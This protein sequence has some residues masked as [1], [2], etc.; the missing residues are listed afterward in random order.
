MAAGAWSQEKYGGRFIYDSYQI[1]AISKMFIG[2]IVTGLMGWL[3]TLAVDLVE[4]MVL[5]WKTTS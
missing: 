2:L 1:L 4:R 5:P 3:L